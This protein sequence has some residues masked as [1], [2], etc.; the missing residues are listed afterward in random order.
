MKTL[1]YSFFSCV[2]FFLFGCGIIVINPK[3]ED[4]TKNEQERIAPDSLES[5]DGFYKAYEDLSTKNIY[6][7]DA[8]TTKEIIKNSD[9][10]FVLIIF[11][12]NWCSP[13]KKQMPYIK[14]FYNKNKN[15]IT[16]LYVST[17]EWS[18][19]NKD[20]EYLNS[21]NLLVGASLV[22]D[23][24]KYGNKLSPKKRFISYFKDLNFSNFD[25]NKIGFPTYVLVK[26]D[27]THIYTNSGIFENEKISNFITS[28]N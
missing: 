3:Y 8:K 24:N 22:V 12:A 13:C 2:V 16:L 7:V 25:S 1:K 18:Q 9:K 26:N 28:T 4:L 10:E 23:I 21:L 14:E 17:S 27:L 11:Y 5:I 6:K 20:R 15:L 19:L